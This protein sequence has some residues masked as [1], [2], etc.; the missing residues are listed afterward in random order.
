[1]MNGNLLG[2]LVN[3][4]PVLNTSAHVGMFA[5][6]DAQAIDTIYLSVLNRHPNAAERSHFIKRFNEATNRSEAIEDLMWV[7]L[8]SSE[9]AWNH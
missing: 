9:F 6:D 5:A 7:L 4:N 1:M 8:N 2:E 3:S